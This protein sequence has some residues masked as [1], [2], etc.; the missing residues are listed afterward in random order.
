MF[1]CVFTDVCMCLLMF[2]CVFTDVC[3]C[4]FTVTLA[5]DTFDGGV[6]AKV[7]LGFPFCVV[8]LISL[9]VSSND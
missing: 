2:A 4:V 5:V 6:V 9:C 3:V 1:V 8:T 7:Y